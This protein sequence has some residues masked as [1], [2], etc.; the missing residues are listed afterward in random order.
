MISETLN[1]LVNYLL[2]F[3]LSIGYIGTFIW[4]LIE[5]SF[6]PWPSELLLIPQGALAQQG[7]LS[8]SLLLL[9]SIAGSLAGAL[10]NYYLALYL[11]RRTINK[12]ISK[13][14]NF[15]FLKEN[16]LIKSEEY[17]KKH[18]EITTFVGRLI[19]AIRQLISLPAGFSRMKLPKFILFTS[20]GAGIWSAI[21]LSLG[22]FLGD[23][24]E[25]IAQNLKLITIITI[26]LSLLIILIYLIIRLRVRHRI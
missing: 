25:L 7:Q 16:H 13:Y 22:Y 17:F 5:S 8:F 2:D 10:I 11:G 20:L 15:L 24:I 6:I 19:P 1:L 26:F 12:L 23:N 14:G 9:A 21:L 18:G 3:S 4:M